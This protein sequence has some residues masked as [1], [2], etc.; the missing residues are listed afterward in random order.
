MQAEFEESW[1]L[2]TDVDYFLEK[3]KEGT[4]ICYDVEKTTVSKLK[5]MLKKGSNGVTFASISCV[6]R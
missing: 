6:Q 4:I 2:K 3:L 1:V 5:G